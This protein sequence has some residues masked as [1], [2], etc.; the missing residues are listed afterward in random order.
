MTFE[1]KRMPAAAKQ[2][3]IFLHL[4]GLFLNIARDVNADRGL[5]AEESGLVAAIYTE[6]RSYCLDRAKIC[7][8]LENKG[9]PELHKSALSDRETGEGHEIPPNPPHFI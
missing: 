3:V 1:N 8:I 7:E 5:T 2:K 6:L 9:Q 4:A